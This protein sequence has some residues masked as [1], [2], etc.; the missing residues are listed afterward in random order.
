MTDSSKGEDVKSLIEKLK[1]IDVARV[2]EDEG[3]KGEAL[4]LA[5]KITST[6]EGPINRATDLVFRVCCTTSLY[7]LCWRLMRLTALHFDCGAYCCG[8]GFVQTSR[9]WFRYGHF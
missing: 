4:A 1:N 6:L 7:D 8:L 5:R 2:E 3:V 9:V